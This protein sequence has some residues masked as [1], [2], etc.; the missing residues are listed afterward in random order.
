MGKETICLI[1]P[2][3]KEMNL[4]IFFGGKKKGLHQSNTLLHSQ[5]LLMEN[6]WQDSNTGQNRKLH[7]WF[8]IPDEALFWGCK[9]DGVEMGKRPSLQG[10]WFERFREMALLKTC[11]ASLLCKAFKYLFNINCMCRSHRRVLLP[12]SVSASAFTF[13]PQ[14]TLNPSKG[15]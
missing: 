12:S 14:S 9:V 10:M 8:I 11:T 6:N 15:S 4:C 3:T 1:P 13:C 2:V 7:S 5:F